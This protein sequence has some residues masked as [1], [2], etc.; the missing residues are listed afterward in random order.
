MSDLYTPT[1]DAISAW[2]TLLSGTG[3]TLARVTSA[4][5][6]SG[7]CVNVVEGSV[8]GGCAE[9]TPGTTNSA[10]T[11][12]SE[13]TVTLLSSWRTRTADRNRRTMAHELGHLLGLD[14]NAC[15]TADSVMSIAPDCSTTS[16][17][18]LTP[19]TTDK[20]PTTSSTYGNN[21]QKTCR[22]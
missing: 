9:T 21:A 2:N 7:D 3:V 17:L 22:Y 11:F 1:D 4:C 18:A 16:G 15:G 6:T 14:H 8:S 20:L 13:S 5:G 10:G 19:T 12:T